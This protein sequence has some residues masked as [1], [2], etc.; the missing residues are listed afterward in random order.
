MFSD[1]GSSVQNQIEVCTEYCQRNYPGEPVTIFRD[2]G[3]SAASTHRPDFQKMLARIKQ[4][5]CRILVCYRLDRLS[6]S[7]AEFSDTLNLLQRHQSAFISV[8]EHFDTTTPIGTAMIYIAAVFAQLERDVI[9]ERVRDNMYR[10]AMDGHWS[11]GTTPTGYSSKRQ[12]YVDQGGK[13][14]AFFSLEENEEEM[15]LVEL[16]VQK[17]EEIGTGAGVE[18]YCLQNGIKSRL[19]NDLSREAIFAILTNPVYCTADETAFAYYESLGCNLVD[20]ALFDGMHGLLPYNRQKTM[21]GGTL[22]NTDPAEWLIAV[23]EHRGKFP[24]ERWIALQNHIQQNK[25]TRPRSVR[26]SPALLSGLLRCSCGAYM[27]PKTYG[28]PLPDG[29]KKYLYVCEMKSRSRGARCSVKNAPGMA[30]DSLV[31]DTLRKLASG[32][33]LRALAE[34]RLTVSDRQKA[35]QTDLAALKAKLSEVD[36]Q[37]SNLVAS[38]SALNTDAARKVL[39]AQLDELAQRRES[40]T[41]D[42]ELLQSAYTGIAQDSASI[43]YMEGVLQSV[44][45]H[46]DDIDPRTLRLQLQSLIDGIDWDGQHAEIQLFGTRSTQ[47]RA[48]NPHLER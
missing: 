16:L 40:L 5:E 18:A 4:R 15:R 7:V 17:Y 28:K 11:G 37:V 10:L 35:V 38:M 25:F 27:R 29:T 42:M 9:A 6:R 34:K 46:C 45:D 19:G 44:V 39:A 26:T 14:K 48:Q 41:H 12:S 23:G 3:Y 13:E 43:D 24:S 30:M 21:P 22:S 33:T 31:V 36:Q 2:D 47:R 1:R 8:S 32:D 20:A